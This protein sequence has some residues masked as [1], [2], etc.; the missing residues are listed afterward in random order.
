MQTVKRSEGRGVIKG[1]VTDTKKAVVLATLGLK[2]VP[3]EQG[4]GIYVS[5]DEKHPK[6]SGG[7]ANFVFLNDTNDVVG[8]YART[9]DEGTA[10]RDLDKLLEAFKGSESPAVRAAVEALEAA[11]TKAA[12]VLGRRFLENYQRMVWF[13]REQAPEIVIIGGEAVQDPA[14]G[15]SSFQGFRFKY[16]PERKGGNGQ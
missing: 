11:F 9:Y 13:L 2:F 1:A 6:S 5:F 8:R 14:T 3:T 10:D 4:G 12:V 16:V 7:V 15:R